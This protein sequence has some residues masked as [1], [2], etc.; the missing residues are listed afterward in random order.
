MQPVDP[1]ELWDRPPFEPAIGDTA[2]GK[3]IFGRGASDDKGQVMTFLEAVRA[4]KRVTG[5]IPGR[6]TVL[7]EGEEESSSPSLVP[8]LRA[9]AAELRAG[10]ALVCDTGM[11]GRGD[12]GDLDDA[13]RV[14]WGTS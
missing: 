5:R 8:F 6:L 3:V 11:M 14:W 9:N 4:W 12:A 7:I 1:L 10:M 2:Q 13:A